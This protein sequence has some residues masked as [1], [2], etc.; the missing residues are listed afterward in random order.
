MVRKPVLR[1]RHTHGPGFKPWAALAAL[2]DD[3]TMSDLCE[4]FEV[5]PP[6]SS[7]ASG[8]CFKA[9]RH[10]PLPMARMQ[11]QGLRRVDCLN[12]MHRSSSD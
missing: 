11:A 9:W 5:I 3:K 1:A 7:I 10:Q 12:C 2:R 6:G 8:Y 4:E